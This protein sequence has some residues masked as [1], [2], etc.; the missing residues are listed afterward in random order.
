MERILERVCGIDVH[1]DTVV[2]CIRKQGKDG[3]DEQITQTFGTTTVNLLALSDWLN[4]NQVTHVA[5]E[6][7]GIYWK[8]IYYILEDSFTVVLVNAA[9]IKNVP[10]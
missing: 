10:G 8:P 5:M 9:H 2:A 4:A 6:S 1:K 7:T 3:R